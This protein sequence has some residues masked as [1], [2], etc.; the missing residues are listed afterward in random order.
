MN[1][2]T[3]ESQS[4][5]PEGYCGCIKYISGN[6]RWY[7][8]GIPHRD[9]GPAVIFNDGCQ[10][11]YKN[12]KYHREDGPAVIW[13]NYQ[14]WYLDDKRYSRDG[15]YHELYKRGIITEQELF[16]ELL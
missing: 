1:L 2:I 12:G 5:V 6:E 9:N 15:Y 11:W 4:E 14:A 8:N 10:Y 7:K 3:V 16:I 13:S